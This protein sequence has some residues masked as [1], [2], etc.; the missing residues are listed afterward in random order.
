MEL[1]IFANATPQTTPK[2]DAEQI[3]SAMD[4]TAQAIERIK[5]GEEII[6][7]QPAAI[8]RV[9]QDDRYQVEINDKGHAVV[10]NVKDNDGNWVKQEE[11][12]EENNSEVERI[13]SLYAAELGHPVSKRSRE[14]AND[15]LN[16]NAYGLEFLANGMNDKGKK[17]FTEVTGISLP[18]QQGATWKVIRDWAGVSDE[19]EN[20]RVAMRD[21]AYAVKAFM[22]DNNVSQDVADKNKELIASKIAEGFNSIEKIGNNYWFTDG[23]GQ[24]INLSEKPKK[25]YLGLSKSRALIEAMIAEAKAAKAKEI[26]TK[27]KAIFT[28]EAKQDVKEAVHS[29]E[30]KTEIKDEPKA[31]GK[32]VV[33]VYLTQGGQD[34]LV[35]QQRKKNN[36]E[37][38]YDYDGKFGAGSGHSHADMLKIVNGIKSSKR[39]VKLGYGVE[40]ELVQQSEQKAEQPKQDKPIKKSP[41]KA[42][43]SKSEFNKAFGVNESKIDEIAKDFERKSQ[44][45]SVQSSEPIKWFGSM[46]K[47]NDWIAKQTNGNYKVVRKGFKYEVF[48]V[49]NEPENSQQPTKSEYNGFTDNMSAKEAGRV[50]S[51]LSVT[52]DYGD[53]GALSR[54][55]LIEQ[56]AKQGVFSES[57]TEIQRIKAKED[58]PDAYFTSAGYLRDKY[59]DVLSLGGFTITKTE[60]EYSQYLFEKNKEKEIF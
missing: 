30:K 10:K 34:G 9:K 47:A 41:L 23:K 31:Y 53:L 27:D 1:T 35:I 56:F 55:E 44:N 38:V 57:N 16:K 13:A 5:N 19:Q 18:K 32:N 4:K 39:G 22:R 50:K 25:G 45:E 7:K 43:A 48:V 37:I 12:T 24:G 29:V 36:G 52:F 14:F 6:Y 11:K 42:T 49:P 46:E 20:H 54:S 17:V 3:A 60:H 26:N 2:T 21:V 15:I 28:E 40:F 58:H 51:V 8:E 33:S 59:V